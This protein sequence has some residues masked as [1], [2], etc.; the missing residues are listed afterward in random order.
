MFAFGP[1][2]WVDYG[3]TGTALDGASEQE[4]TIRS[5]ADSLAEATA[6]T[7]VI[8]GDQQANLDTFEPLRKAAGKAPVRF[9]AARGHNHFSDLAPAT[10]LIASRLVREA[11]GG[12]AFALA[13]ADLAAAR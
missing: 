4:L 13:E 2:D 11:E 5:P 1:V 8:E 7:F 6:P 12:P 10:E 3:A 9:L